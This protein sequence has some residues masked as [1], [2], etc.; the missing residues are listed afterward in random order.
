MRA[1]T[2]R[3]RRFE[4]D[5]VAEAYDLSRPRF[6]G[7][8]VA[9]LIA[10]SGLKTGDRV[11]EIGAGTGQLTGTLLRA[12]LNVDAL[13]PGAN[14][15]AKLKRN[16]GSSAGLHVIGAPFEDYAGDQ[17]YDAIAAANSFHW[18]DPAISYRKAQ[19][20]LKPDGALTLL[21]NLPIL[22][23]TDLQAKLNA[24]AFVGVLEQFRREP[25]NYWEALQGLFEAGRQEMIES[26]CF[27]T[28]DWTLEKQSFVVAPC[29]YIDLLN[30]FANGIGLRAEI[31]AS[32]MP[33]IADRSSL[34]LI[35]YVYLCVA[36]RA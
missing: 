24:Q 18:L 23:D 21:W 8:I 25:F 5:T 1:N 12:G 3:S 27:K 31:E 22:A 13:E 9:K 33:L 34:E 14:L 2:E 26:G 32:V 30:S 7:A 29:G 19:S 36:R 20:L 16:L 6:D 15:G 17:P 11:L 35:N 10:R 28:R 4:F